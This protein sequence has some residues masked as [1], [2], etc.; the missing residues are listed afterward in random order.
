MVV[1]TVS[2]KGQVVIPQEVRRRLDLRRGTRVQLRVRKGVVELL[3][4]PHEK[5]RDWKPWRGSLRRRQVL[6][7]LEAE[8]ARE[9][10][11]R[12]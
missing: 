3:P 7:A 8:H 5:E 2:S 10:A 11:Q 12:S 9:I 6:A 4:L 1:V